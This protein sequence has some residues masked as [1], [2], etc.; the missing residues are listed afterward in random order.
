MRRGELLVFRW[1]DVD[2]P[3]RCIV[4]RDTENG[5]A[6][7]P[8]LTKVAIGILQ[9]LRRGEGCARAITEEGFKSVWQRVLA[10]GRERVLRADPA[11]PLSHDLR[12]H[13]LRH[14]ALSRLAESGAIASAMDLQAIS[15]HRDPRM[16]LR[17]PI[18]SPA[19]AIN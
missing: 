9:S 11:S 4:L 7:R 10:R 17:Y 3:R 6:H 12:F 2:W 5:R 18:T 1:V 19:A 8:P 14:E 13:N 16:L 15:G